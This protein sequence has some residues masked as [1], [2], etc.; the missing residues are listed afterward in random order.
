MRFPLSFVFPWAIRVTIAGLMLATAG[1][2]KDGGKASGG[3]RKARAV[4]VKVATA[5]EEDLPVTQEAIGN[6][7]AFRTVAVRSQVDG[8]IEAIH[9]REGQDVK[10]GDLLVTI[11]R[12]P[13]ATQVQIARADLAQAE[14]EAA[15]AKAE[16]ERY[17][18]LARQQVVSKEQ[19]AQL[20]TRAEVTRAVV[21]V[22]KGAL[23]AA[24]LQLSY[25]EI[26]APIPGRV[27]QRFLHE[28][29]LVKA[30]DTQAA[31]VINQ[32]EPVFVTFSVAE[33]SLPKVRA[34]LARGEAPV[35]AHGADGGGAIE[36]RLDFVDNAV[37]PATGM[38]L[39]K[40]VFA[41]KRHRLWPGQFVRVA[42]E[43]G[44]EKKAVLVPER[45]VTT[46]QG[47]A[48]IFALT[49]NGTV[50]FREVK[51]GLRSGGRVEILEGVKAGETVVTDGQLR[52]VPGA[53]V[54]VVG[55]GGE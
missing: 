1:C 20:L 19:Y 49:A 33:S 29:A 3:G 38:I 28:G 53:K 39:L 36:G 45:A 6:V 55:G 41:N 14:A 10:E 21:E 8:L 47:G 50:D 48:R 44:V 18:E 40:A 22:K 35:R 16:A 9:F 51:T 46:G 25:A 24:E 5:T 43:L 12:R 30:N 13:L 4:P 37:D 42:L 34:A 23:A 27:G 54:D 31:A 32:L 17:E 52:L 7:Q 11:D 2:D 15:Q 26:R